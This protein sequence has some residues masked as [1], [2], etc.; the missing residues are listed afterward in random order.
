MKT[1]IIQFLDNLA[2]WSLSDAGLQSW[3]PGWAAPIAKGTDASLDDL[4]HQ[5]EHELQNSVLKVHQFEL[6]VVV[7]PEISALG[8]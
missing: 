1:Y 4:Q 7:T 3:D 5:S 6:G 8:R 2:H